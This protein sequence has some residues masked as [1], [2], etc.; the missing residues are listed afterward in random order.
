MRQFV[1]DYY[2]VDVPLEA[3]DGSN[4]PSRL[5]ADTAIDVAREQARLYVTPCEWQVRE[6]RGDTVLVRRKRFAPRRTAP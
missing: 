6:Q 5:Q 4:N 3:F 1:Y 2:R